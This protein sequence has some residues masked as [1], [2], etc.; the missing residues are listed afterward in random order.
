MTRAPS[1]PPF[2]LDDLPD[3]FRSDV[4]GH[5]DF[6]L[7]RLTEA[8]LDPVLPPPETGRVWAFSPFVAQTC[9]RRPEL[10]AEL[11][12][13]GDL[14]RAYAKGELADRVAAALAGAQTEEACLAALR[15]LRQREMVRIAWRDLAGKAKLDE[16]LG[17]LTD[18]AEQCL[19]GALTWAEAELTARHGEPRGR[20]GAPQ[21]LVVIGMGKLGGREL[22]YSSDIDLI[23]AYPQ[24]G[25]T[26]G[27][28]QL[29]NHQFFIRLGQRL[30]KLISQLT[31]DG[32]V[33]RV[34]MRLRPFGDPGPLAMS[35]D[36]TENYYQT[37][38]REWERYALIKARVVAGDR[39]RGEELMEALR[40]FVYRR[41]LDYGVFAS[42]RDMKA[43][44]NREA[45]RKDMVDNIK[46]G[47]GGIREVEF[48]GQAFQLIRGGRDPYLQ[49]RSIQEILHRLVERGLLPGYVNQQLQAAY[50]FLRRAEN[51]LQE[52]GDQQ[53]HTLPQDEHGQ[54]RLAH[55]M[56]FPDWA[57]FRSALDTHM[58][59]VHE[60]FGQ[61]FG[62]P[63]V[64]NEAGEPHRDEL[65]NLWQG[66]LSAQ[67][68]E[69]Q[70]QQAGF[71]DAAAALAQLEALRQGHAVRALSPTG[72]E[73]LDQ[74]MPLLIGAVGRAKHANATL[75][76]VLRLVG[77]V[78]RRSVYLALLSESPI[79]L[80][81]LVRLCAASP[82]LADHLA[83]YP[84]LL[85][86]LLDPRS[87]YAPLPR[88][89]LA[90]E[91]RAELARVDAA[92]LEQLM[93]RLRHFKQAQVLRVAAA[94]VM[95]V[96]PLMKVSD[97]L[98]WIAEA[99]LGEVLAIAW[100][101]LTER[102]GEPRCVV[103]GAQRNAGFAIIAYG[104]LAGLELGYGSDLD[105]V[106][107]HDSAG[108]RQET[109][110]EKPI[111]N[112]VFFARLAQRIIHILT[113][114]T[115]AGVLYEV[116]TR[117]R[118]SGA[119]GL[120]VSG[121]AAFEQYQ[122]ESAWTWEHQAIVRA[123]P[124]AGEPRIAQAFQA[125]RREVLCR[126][127][128]RGQLRKEVREM[129][130]RM[131][132]ELG[133]KK[134]GVFDLKKDPGGIADIEFVVQYN[135]LAHASDHP[136][137]TE[138]TDNIRILDGLA[139][140]GLMSAED[141]RLLTDA[142]RGYRDRVHQLTLQEQP[143]VVPDEEFAEY[144]AQV[145]RIWRQVLED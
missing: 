8:G 136:S 95:Q 62:A 4:V 22:N 109:D 41:Y 35:F 27:E 17:D 21:R 123:R 137:L 71:G 12:A 10:F 96:L 97:Q 115:P 14:G 106:F 134:P 32:F 44:I 114:F 73:R 98:T 88:D 81:Q 68:A 104:K 132:A 43:L 18:L 129:R 121:L 126:P 122:R 54:A 11:L 65:S 1:P 64:E 67:D 55:S 34:D 45:S 58:R 144:R 85:D 135:V 49:V 91:L 92:D 93:D 143:A 133:S 70:L 20:D 69:R 40:P 47:A 52:A 145:Q 118:P 112:T 83:R 36:A 141:A 72:R 127:R 2:P 37:H 87:L 119:S 51:R 5:W 60:H 110:G 66:A 131:W 16:T 56:G 99:V 23:F 13:S 24:D 26:D 19:E 38:G 124:V 125:V 30:I 113:A 28:K 86:E 101:G 82:W 100:R 39:V 29:D 50:G 139:G 53:T 94:D 108:E 102:H 6:Y 107:L 76:R 78:A 31:A 9:G 90:E 61:V 25:V 117:L 57:A 63:Q 128:D 79:A 111:E 77:T 116:D 89:A 15:R 46:L 59:H 3:A 80:S 33:F 142:Y 42:L 84:L 74:L 7:A 140:C 75:E 130:E 103:E 138:F 120:M 48:I 105:I